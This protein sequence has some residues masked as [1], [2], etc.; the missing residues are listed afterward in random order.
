MAVKPIKRCQLRY[1]DPR[2]LQWV[3]CAQLTLTMITV[4]GA[5]W[6][7]CDEHEGQVKAAVRTGLAGG[8]QWVATPTPARRRRY[9]V[10][11]S[12]LP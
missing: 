10:Q 1:L 5:V 2:T 7:V 12:L 3:D 8:L 11:P 4:D 9:P 6:R